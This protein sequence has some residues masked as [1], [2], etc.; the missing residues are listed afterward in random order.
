ML[1]FFT[2]H[3]HAFESQGHEWM[4][5]LFWFN[6]GKFK[7]HLNWVACLEGAVALSPPRRSF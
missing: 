1:V 3:N 5:Y 6:K 4:A 7:A 2:E